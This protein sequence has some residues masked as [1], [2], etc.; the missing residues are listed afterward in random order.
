MPI[1]PSVYCSAPQ[2]PLFYG[3]AFKNKSSV[4]PS[5]PQNGSSTKRTTRLGDGKSGRGPNRTATTWDFCELHTGRNS[6]PAFKYIWCASMSSLRHH[7][8][9]QGGKIWT[10]KAASLGS[11]PAL[12]ERCGVWGSCS[13][14]AA[15]FQLEDGL[16]NGSGELGELLF[17][18]CHEGQTELGAHAMPRVMLGSRSSS[19]GAAQSGL[20]RIKKKVKSLWFITP[21]PQ[22]LYT[23]SPSQETGQLSERAEAIRASPLARSSW[24]RHRFGSTDFESPSESQAW[25]SNCCC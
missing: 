18:W 11:A 7:T 9:N 12:G 5:W 1:N 20:N 4:R 10:W 19:S 24:G 13:N 14:V 21:R 2:Q 15:P 23:T 16:G 17:K 22:D 6:C 8:S 3:C 25:W